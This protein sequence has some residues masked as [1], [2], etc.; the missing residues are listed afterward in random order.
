MRGVCAWCGKDLELKHRSDLPVISHG[1]CEDCF[2]DLRVKETLKRLQTG[3][4]VH[5]IFVPPT[6]EDLVL[7]IWR[8]GPAACS[9][10]VYPDRRRGE[11][12]AQRRPVSVERRAG[13]DRRGGNLSFLAGALRSPSMSSRPHPGQPAATS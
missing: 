13:G 2:L 12:R 1:I 3:R 7:R 11:R 8:E 5:R 4:D 9:F 10:I 6:R